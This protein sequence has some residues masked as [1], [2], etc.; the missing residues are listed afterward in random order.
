MQNTASC[1]TFTGPAT[2]LSTLPQTSLP[3]LPPLSY[4]AEGDSV[5]Y[6]QGGWRNVRSGS[7]EIY[8]QLS[9]VDGDGSLSVSRLV[10][11]RAQLVQYIYV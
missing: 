4:S 10:K 5:R 1:P 9:L 8:L 6:G 11:H 2:A 3:P 7:V